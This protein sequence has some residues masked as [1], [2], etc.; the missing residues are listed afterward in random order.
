MTNH[1]ITVKDSTGKTTTQIYSNGYSPQQVIKN[2]VQS[3]KQTMLDDRSVAK[4]DESIQLCS[5]FKIIQEV[6]DQMVADCSRV[7][8]AEIFLRDY[9]GIILDNEDTGAITAGM[10][11]VWKSK[12]LKISCPKLCPH[13]KL[14]ILP[15]PRS[16]SAI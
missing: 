16:R 15:I 4:L 9:C 8:D 11:A 13:R 6:I 2:L 10:L 14:A 1:A 5:Q 3:W 12:L 7:G